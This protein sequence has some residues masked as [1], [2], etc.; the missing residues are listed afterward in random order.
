MAHSSN[1]T[2]RDC[3]TLLSAA[4]L[5]A[6]RA[7]SA[8]TKRSLRGAF[9]I[10]ATPYTAAKAIDYED[11][12]GEVDFLDR[13]GTQGMVWP[14]NASDLSY[15]TKDE[16][17]RGMEVIAKAAKG[18]KPALILGVQAEDTPSMLEYAR[19]AEK[20]E[21]D[22]VIAIPPTKATSL[23]DYRE[24]YTELCKLAKRPVFI[25]TAGGSPDVAPTVEFIVEMGR[26]FENFGYLKEEYKS[27]ATAVERMKE[28]AKHRP[29][30][31]KIILGAFRARGWTY[32]MR[33]GMDGTLTGGPMYADVYA[34][35]W[36]LHMAGKRDEVREVY[37]KLLL[38]TNLEQAIPGLR[39]YMMK[40]RGVFKTTVSRRGDYS[41]APDAVA[42]I[43][44]NFAALKPYLRV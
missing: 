34:H 40:H 36:E 24:Y 11:L 19:L 44:Y 8:T 37:S 1:F 39:S 20:L 33:L 25:Q 21:P 29:G 38:M 28:M 42:E 2:R 9:M 4:T 12:E 23:D 14:Q 22:A 31:I 6:G 17:M 5:S 7:P 26:K 3:L 18:R 41:Y 10:L 16:R 30:A 13:C 27:V 43:E 15:L 35:L 32:E